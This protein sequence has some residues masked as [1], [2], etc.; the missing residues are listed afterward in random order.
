[1]AGADNRDVKEAL[2]QSYEFLQEE[3]HSLVDFNLDIVEVRDLK[4]SEE[5]PSSLR[6]C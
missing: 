4:E 3:F 6:H 2:S 5:S 1:M